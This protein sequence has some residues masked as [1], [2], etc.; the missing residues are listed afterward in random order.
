MAC[1]RHLFPCYGD[2]SLIS[3]VSQLPFVFGSSRIDLCL[4][5]MFLYLSTLGLVGASGQ[6]KEGV[7]YSL[8]IVYFIL[9]MC[10]ALQ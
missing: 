5:V 6:L 2:V 4:V 3:L 10:D 9:Y 8:M 7:L 1:S